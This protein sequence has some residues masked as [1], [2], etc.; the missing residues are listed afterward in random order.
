MNDSMRS[1]T[2][3]MEGR[4]EKALKSAGGKDITKKKYGYETQAARN[5]EEFMRNDD[6]LGIHKDT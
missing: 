5:V 2:M 3:D 6:I 1:F 4:L